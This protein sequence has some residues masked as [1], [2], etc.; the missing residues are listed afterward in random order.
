MLKLIDK[1]GKEIEKD[2]ET[3]LRD[4]FPL[5]NFS[6]YGLVMDGIQFKTGEHAFQYL[7]FAKTNSEVAKAITSS[8]SPNEARRLAQVY[9]RLRDP[10]WSNVK[11]GYMKRVFELKAASNKE[12]EEALLNTKDYTI[13][14]HCVDQDTDWGVDNNGVGENNLGKLWMQIREELKKGKGKVVLE[15]V[16][17]TKEQE[18]MFFEIAQQSMMKNAGD[19]TEVK[20]VVEDS[21]TKTGRVV[22]EKKIGC[23]PCHHGSFDEDGRR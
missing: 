4:L 13:V 7:K 2:T 16:F 19:A 21:V 11:Y 6:A 17:A 5:D 12:V 8:T 23:N 1:N 22:K 9:K 15:S 20:D 14:E 3:Y 10:E 18:E